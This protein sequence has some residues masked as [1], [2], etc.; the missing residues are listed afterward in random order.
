VSRERAVDDVEPTVK[1]D[2]QRAG[3]V[4]R[5]RPDGEG[6]GG[7]DRDEEGD[8]AH[9]VRREAEPVGRRHPRAEQAVRH[10]A[11]L[12]EGHLP[13]RRSRPAHI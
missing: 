8:H 11:V 2:E 7:R 5:R 9:L 12:V 13:S 6:G 4:E 10:G 1:E 3:R